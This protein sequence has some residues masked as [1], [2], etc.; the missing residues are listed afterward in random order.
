M[1]HFAFIASI[2][3]ATICAVVLLA[4]YGGSPEGRELLF[5]PSGL[6]GWTQSPGLALAQIVTSLLG[7]EAMLLVL[8]L[9]LVLIV[10]LLLLRWSCRMVVWAASCL[11]LLEGAPTFVQCFLYPAVNLKAE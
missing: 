9:V 7:G 5:G 3:P 1:S 10:L 4:T 6:I 11:F 8:R 2:V